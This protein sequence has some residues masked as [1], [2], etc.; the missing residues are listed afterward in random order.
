MP[1][2]TFT[3]F[4]LHQFCNAK[5]SCAKMSQIRCYSTRK[6]Q[7]FKFLK[8]VSQTLISYIF[9]HYLNCN[10]LLDI[11]NF[12]ITCNV[13]VAY[14]YFVLLTMS[15]CYFGEMISLT[16]L[17]LLVAYTVTSGVIVRDVSIHKPLP[18]SNL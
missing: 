5:M 16:T 7:H 15:H 12:T 14:T 6:T 8:F 1:S 13:S 3:K 11:Y 10:V 4:D 2:S 18:M 9:K 17:E